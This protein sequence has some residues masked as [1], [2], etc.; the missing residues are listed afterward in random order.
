[1]LKDELRHTH[2]L[3]CIDRQAD[4]SYVLLNRNYKPLGFMTGEYVQY[5]EHPVG[6]KLKELGPR[7]AAKISYRGDES[8]ERIY[9]YN[10]GCI[11][12]DGA[13]NM[14]AYLDRLGKVMKL[15]ISD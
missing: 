14:K 9:L 6:V 10:D 1:M 13:A 7:D 4:G 11:P 12:T 3:Y 8:L 15:G 2:F 5:G